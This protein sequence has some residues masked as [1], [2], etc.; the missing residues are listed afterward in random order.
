MD[1]GLHGSDQLE[2]RIGESRD[3][4]LFGVSFNYHFSQEPVAPNKVVWT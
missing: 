2:I 3:F 1:V 4:L